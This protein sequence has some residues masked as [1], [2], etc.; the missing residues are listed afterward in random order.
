MREL[1]V[2]TQFERDLSSIPVESRKKAFD[3][4]SLQTQ[5]RYLQILRGRFGIF[6]VLRNFISHLNLRP[7]KKFKVKN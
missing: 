4:S 1:F 7:L 5:K 6:F 2:T 3:S